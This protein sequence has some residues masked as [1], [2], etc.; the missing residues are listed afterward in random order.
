M[1]AALVSA[2]LVLVALTACSGDSTTASNSSGGTLVISVGGDPETLLPPL[3]STTTGQL[4]G[5]LIYDRLAEIGDSLDTVG[6]HG[7]QPRLAKTWDWSADSLSI[8]FHLDH[9]A[10]WHDGKPVRASDVAFTYRLYT[11][12]ANA[13]QFAAQLAGIDSVTAPDSASAKV[14]FH[15]RSPMQ[16]YDAVNTML[17]IP[18]HQL[19]NLSGKDLQSAPAARAPI[20]SGRFRFR[21]WNAGQSIELV[22]DTANYRGR[23][24]LDRVVIAIAADMNTAITRLAGGEADVLEQIPAASLPQVASDTSLHII[25]APSLDYNFMQFN[26]ARPLFADRELRRALTM[27][28]DRASIVRN[29][30]DSLADVAIGPT[31]RAYPTTDALLKQIPFSREAAMRALDSLGWKDTNGD[32][33]R[34]SN[35]RKLEFRLGVP[36]VSKARNAMATVIQQQLKQVGAN[37]IIDALD[38]PRFVEAES[39]HNFDA[40]LGGWHVEP[41]PGGIR[42]TWGSGGIDGGSNYGSYRNAS[43]D[44][45][46]DSALSASTLAGRRDHFTK[47]YQIINDDAAAVWLA[48]PKRVMAVHKRIQ[49]VGMR[50]DAWWANIADWSIPADKRI[51][52]D[53]IATGR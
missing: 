4:I 31:V 19:A 32:G 10:K 5:D 16:F 51:A 1:R 48:E 36:T 6:D 13:S 26:V 22:A 2:S 40:V 45:H 24:S 43:F 42:Q 15:E 39:T 29:A 21:K 17:I 9:A 37:V 52:R 46:V 53:R 28:L 8:T 7:F 33:I 38:I 47:A 3:A 34:E 20:G 12:T 50:P 11:D 44:A 23:A 25:L 41:S 35:G 27:A 30:Y 49:T 14:W 18:E